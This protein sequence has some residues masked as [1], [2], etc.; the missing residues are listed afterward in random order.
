MSANPITRGRELEVVI[1]ETAYEV[2][3]AIARERSEIIKEKAAVVI[4]IKI[5]II[6]NPTQIGADFKLMAAFRPS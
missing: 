1:V 6:L 2:S 4:E 5:E 3:Q